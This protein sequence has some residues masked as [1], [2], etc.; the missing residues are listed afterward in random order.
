VLLDLVHGA[1]S[2]SGLRHAA[3]AV[4]DFIALTFSV[5]LRRRRRRPCLH[6]QAVR[7]YAG[8]P[9]VAVLGGERALDRGVEVGIVEHDEGRVAAELHRRLLHRLRALLEEDLATRSSR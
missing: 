3:H 7:A 1:L 5:S 6:E 4:S 2:I 8:L 9:G